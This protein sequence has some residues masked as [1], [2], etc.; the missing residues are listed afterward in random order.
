MRACSVLLRW[1]VFFKTIS[2]YLRSFYLRSLF[3]EGGLVFA[4]GPGWKRY[5][6]CEDSRHYTWLQVV[7]LRGYVRARFS[8]THRTLPIA[9]PSKCL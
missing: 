9:I 7:T 1:G 4:F 6:E 5:P 8:E 3:G 2:F